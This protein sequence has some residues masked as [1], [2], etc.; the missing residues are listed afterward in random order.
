MSKIDSFWGVDL[1]GF[2]LHWQLSSLHPKFIGV[3]PSN[4]VCIDWLLLTSQT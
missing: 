4:H 2:L 3:C 1:Q